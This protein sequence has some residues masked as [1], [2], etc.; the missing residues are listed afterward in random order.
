MEYAP[1][2]GSILN[3]WLPY[4]A[5]GSGCRYHTDLPFVLSRC[6]ASGSQVNHCTRIP[7]GKHKSTYIV[8]NKEKAFQGCFAYVQLLPESTDFRL[9]PSYNT[10]FHHTFVVTLTMQVCHI[11]LSL[12]HWL[13]Q[14]WSHSSVSGCPWTPNRWLGSCGTCQKQVTSLFS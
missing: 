6:P 10:L 2:A 14:S 11:L 12:P 9:Y 1:Q 5:T 7:Q 4:K 8:V 13:Q 3:R